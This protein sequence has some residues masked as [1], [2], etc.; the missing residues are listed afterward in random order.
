MYRTAPVPTGDSFQGLPRLCGETA[1]N[2]EYNMIF[3]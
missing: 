1:D 3:L 2:T